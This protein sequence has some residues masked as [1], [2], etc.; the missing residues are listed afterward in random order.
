MYRWWFNSKG[1]DYV[2]GNFD[3]QWRISRHTRVDP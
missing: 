1:A 2:T 3:G